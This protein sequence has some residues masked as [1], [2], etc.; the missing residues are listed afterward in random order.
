MRGGEGNGRIQMERGLHRRGQRFH[1]V[2]NGGGPRAGHG[3]DINGAVM[4]EEFAEEG[5]KNFSPDGKQASGQSFSALDA[6]T[7]PFRSHAGQEA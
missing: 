4:R 2:E 1:A 5:E 6:L 3:R 7:A